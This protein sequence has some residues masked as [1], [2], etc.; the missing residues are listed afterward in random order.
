M[1]VYVAPPQENPFIIIF[2]Q[3]F[4]SVL[5]ENTHIKSHFNQNVVAFFRQPNIM[6]PTE[7]TRLFVSCSAASTLFCLLLCTYNIV[8][9]EY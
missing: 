6:P 7:V 4:P 5:H 2:F 9:M 1:V 8:H 3:K